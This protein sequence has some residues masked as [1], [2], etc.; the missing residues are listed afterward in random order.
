MN[1]LIDSIAA[2]TVNTTAATAAM[3]EQSRSRFAVDASAVDNTNRAMVRIAQ[4]VDMGRVGAARVIDRVQ[5]EVPVDRIAPANRFLF[6]ERGREIDFAFRD[7][8]GGAPAGTMR[9]HP[10]ALKQ[11]G[12]I[13]DMPWVRELSG[14]AKDDDQ[15][16]ARLA[17]QS[18]NMF[19]KRS[20][21]RHLIRSV[22]DQARGIVS[23]KFKRIDARPILEAALGA[24][25]EVG[26][27][28]YEGRWMETRLELQAIVPQLY[29]PIPGELIAFGLSLRTSDYGDGAF[30]LRTFVLRPACANGMIGQSE[31]RAIH[32]GKRLSDN[33]LLSEKTKRL[34]T[35]AMASATTD[36]IRATLAPAA[37]EAKL[38]AMRAAASREVD[39]ARALAALRKGLQ[40]SEAEQVLAHFSSPDIVTL[41]P[42]NN[43]LRMANAISWLA[44]TEA[45]QRRAVEL[46]EIAGDWIRGSSAS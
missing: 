25:A 17:A 37:I 27:Q 41:P 22:G 14:R 10:H 21:A 13:A 46:Q 2:N 40:K 20:D 15:W 45:N 24:F 35:E 18:L 9:L 8:D 33:E 39:P 4:L 3:A 12:E 38:S 36:V 5:N 29:A 23:D 6:S 30:D 11:V 43:A 42:G 28:P 34:D 31:L 16:G 19:F 26:L 1:T 7:A 32:S 44:N